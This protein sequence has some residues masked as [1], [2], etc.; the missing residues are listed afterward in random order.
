[1]AESRALRPFVRWMIILCPVGVALYFALWPELDAMKDPPIPGEVVFKR[2]RPPVRGASTG[3]AG[4]HLAETEIGLKK[5]SGWSMDWLYDRF[6]EVMTWEHNPWKVQPNTFGN[7]YF[8]LLASSDPKDQ[9]LVLEIRRLGELLH[10][11]VLERYPELAVT[12]KDVPPE[13]NGFLKWLEFSERFDADPSRPGEHYAKVL[14]FPE[15]LKKHISGEGPWDA[16][17]MTA[18]LA[19]EQPLL[20]ELRTIGLMPDQSMV[21]VDLER[22]NIMPARLAKSSAEAWGKGFQR[23]VQQSGITQAAFAIMKGEPVPNDPVHGLP[24]RWDPASRTLSAPNSPLF[25]EVDLKPITVP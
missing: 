23:A 10:K 16:A 1:M 8:E 14:E 19:K 18:W 3:G 17:A 5:G 7:H 9:A 12:F 20:D 4:G 2:E 25:S 11:R 22:W 15:T 6:D 21:G 13:K 24:Y